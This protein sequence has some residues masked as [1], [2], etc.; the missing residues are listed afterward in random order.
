MHGMCVGY[1]RV[2]S[3]DQRIERQLE[4]LKPYAPGKIFED[5]ASGKDTERPGFRQMMEF[6]RDGDQLVVCSMDRLA[7]NLKDLWE[8]IQTLMEKGVSVRFIKENLYL[9]SRAEAD[10]MTKLVFSMMGAFAEFERS[11]IRERQREGIALAKMRGVYKGRKPIDPK[12]IEEA[13]QRKAAGEPMSRIA[14]DL[15]VGRATLYRYMSKADP[16]RRVAQAG[17][18]TLCVLADDT[19]TEEK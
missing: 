2:S 11:L 7:R 18:R 3:D 4:D 14:E 19:P 6:V 8:T 13:R 12:L 10:P 9:S 5:R 15:R 16:D 1:V 17:L